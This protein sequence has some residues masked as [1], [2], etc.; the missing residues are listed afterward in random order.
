[1]AFSK[2]T[3]NFQ[4]MPLVNENLTFSENGVA[5]IIATETFKESRSSSFEVKIPTFGANVWTMTV[6]N[7]ENVSNIGIGYYPPPGL[8]NLVHISSVLA[9]SDGVSTTY[10]VISSV[11][12]TI[13]LWSTQTQIAWTYSFSINSYAENIATNY[14]DAFNFDYNTINLY[15]VVETIGANGLGIV[16]ITATY[17]NAVFAT[18]TNTC[19]AIIT[20]VN[21]VAIIPINILSATFS[22]GSLSSN[23]VVNV[24][25]SVQAT[26]LNMPLIINPVTTNPFSYT[27]ARSEDRFLQVESAVAISPHFFVRTPAELKL[28]NTTINIINTPTGATVT[29]VVTSINLLTLQYS[30]DNVNWR[31]SNI[32]NGIANGSYVMY[33]K[34]QFGYSIQKAFTVS[35][36]LGGSIVV[37]PYFIIPIPNSIRFA[38]RFATKKNINTTLSNEEPVMMP[39]CATQKF[40]TTDKITTQIKTSYSSLTGY[41][42]DGVTNT[43]ITMSKKTSY[44]GAKDKR[45]GNV[46]KRPDGNLGVSFIS[47]NLYNYDTNA[48]IG[49]YDSGGNLPAWASIGGFFF[50][51]TIGYLA[52]YDIVRNETDSFWEIVAQHNYT[53][54]P[55]SEKISTIYNAQGYEVYEFDLVMLSYKNKQIQIVVQATNTAWDNVSYASEII[56]VRD[57]FDNTVE[58]DYWNDTNVGHMNYQTGIVNKMIHDGLVTNYKPD[59]KQEVHLG[60]TKAI[61]VDSTLN[62]TFELIIFEVTTAI[63]RQIAYAMSHKFIKIDNL[64]YVASDK[65]DIEKIGE[66]TNLYSIKVKLIEAG[67]FYSEEV[68]TERATGD[69]IELLTAGYDYLKI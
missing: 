20:I 34:E 56:E 41:I 60:D 55:F 32:F 4:R 47:G 16:E 62:N 66:H 57:S 65:I 45:D 18:V 17:N 37:A 23:I 50:V 15:T 59:G 36:A 27:F 64:L 48:V 40:L 14:R 19:G 11:Q 69:L 67:N 29:P 35:S 13:Y 53:G 61:L 68:V 25:T 33:I 21:Q 1:M 7:T 3:I 9:Y 58:I 8:F 39:Y 12:P 10:S 43:A 44:I 2:I 30:I 22:A 63:A 28:A 6:P 24:T 46:R 31:T 51:P 49:T 42:T 5:S 26:K 54:V 52:I 38:E